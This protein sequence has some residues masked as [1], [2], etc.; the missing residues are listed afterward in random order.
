IVVRMHSGTPKRTRTDAVLRELIACW[1]RVLW[2]FYA[3]ADKCSGVLGKADNV[4]ESEARTW[5]AS[6]M[7][8]SIQAALGAHMVVPGCR[9]DVLGTC[10]WAWR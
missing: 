5:R 4:Q 9:L 8:A 7:H 2:L 1:W 10:A 3:W 6:M